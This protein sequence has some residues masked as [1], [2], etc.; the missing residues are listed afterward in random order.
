MVLAAIGRLPSTI[1]DRCV[2]IRLRR[3]LADEMVETLRI[4]RTERLDIIARQA[5]RWTKDNAEGIAAADPMM[6]KEIFNRQA[7]NWAPLFAVADL[8]GP[9]WGGYARDAATKISGRG[10]AS[11]RELLLT[12][13]QELF[14][15]PLRNLSPAEQFAN[16]L[17]STLFTKEI[18]DFLCSKD[19]RPWPEWGKERKPMTGPQLA[20]MLKPLQIPTGKAVRRGEE[21]AKGYR[22]ED[23]AD[24]FK[25]YARAPD[26]LA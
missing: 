6:P 10:E 21:V 11:M 9:R 17:P 22:R 16:P 3:R 23:L 20:S 18:L 26:G 19:D 7:D 14:N 4:G 25:R 1:E 12:D 5:A 15:T 8:M 2:K 13:I 24:A